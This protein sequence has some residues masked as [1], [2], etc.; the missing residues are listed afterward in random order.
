[1]LKVVKHF[2]SFLLKHDCLNVCALASIG[3]SEG[4]SVILCQAAETLGARSYQLFHLYHLS[5]ILAVTTPITT[6]QILV[7]LALRDY[8][9]SGSLN[10]TT[11]RL[12]DAFKESEYV[13]LGGLKLKRGKFGLKS[14]FI[15]RT[16]QI[17]LFSL[18]SDRSPRSRRPT[19]TRTTCNPS[20]CG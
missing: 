5:L 2:V 14:D 10:R 15:P 8:L 9:T 1:M 11:I 7:R 13:C 3:L 6:F 17:T 16:P 12:I 4:S 20:R 18:P 19:L